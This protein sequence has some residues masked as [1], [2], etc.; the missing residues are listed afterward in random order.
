[1]TTP[2]EKESQTHW[3]IVSIGWN[4]FQTVLAAAMVLGVPLAFVWGWQL[5]RTVEDAWYIPAFLIM[6]QVGLLLLIAPTALLHSQL[7]RSRGATPGGLIRTLFI[8]NI[9]STSL[10]F[11]Y[12][13]LGIL[14]ILIV[15][16]G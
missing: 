10:T 13:S 7:L 16:F 9:I 15:Q 1:M 12:L 4:L 3:S 2:F 14:R 5:S 6:A 11:F 8:L